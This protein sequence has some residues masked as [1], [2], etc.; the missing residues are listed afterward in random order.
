MATHSITEKGVNIRN[1][2]ISVT[3]SH[4]SWAK[5][6]A[7]V[8]GNEQTARGRILSSAMSRLGNHAELK[9]RSGPR[10]AKADAA[11]IR[12][13]AR[14]YLMMEYLNEHSAYD[15][16]DLMARYQNGRLR[17]EGADRDL[18][19]ARAYAEGILAPWPHEK[20][21]ELARETIAPLTAD[22]RQMTA[23]EKHI[24]DEKIRLLSN[25]DRRGAESALAQAAECLNRQIETELYYHNMNGDMTGWDIE[26]IGEMPRQ[27]GLCIYG[28]D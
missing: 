24:L 22:G 10:D 26:I 5:A 11:E 18:S 16:G 20:I 9:R 3:I 13:G 27:I 8:N 17:T 23:M 6:C 1:H 2:R 28:E 25:A 4:E 19:M 12:A 14:Y 7:R 15:P 21:I